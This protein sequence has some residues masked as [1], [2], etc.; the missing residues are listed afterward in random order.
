M[1]L[2]C[3]CVCVCVLVGGGG[4]VQCV[5]DYQSDMNFTSDFCLFWFAFWQTGMEK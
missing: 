5:Y 1:T 4:G 3:V 2:T